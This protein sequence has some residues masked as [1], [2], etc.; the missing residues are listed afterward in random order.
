VY[1][2]LHPDRIRE[3]AER[4][5]GEVEGR[6]PGSG[7]GRVAAEVAEVARRA[8]ERCAAIRKGSPGLRLGI[9]VLVGVGLGALLLVFTNV[10]VTED[11][12]RIENF[13]QEINNVLG[14]V[15][16]LGAAIAFLVSLENRW[17]RGRALSAVGELRAL[18]HV[19]D[20]HQLTKDSY[21]AHDPSRKA[22]S[23]GAAA[24]SPA[25]LSR[26]FEFCSE[27]LS[28][29]AKVGAVYV[30]ALPDPVAL[31]E[32]DEL[33]ELCLGLSHKIWQKIALVERP[34]RSRHAAEDDEP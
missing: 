4:L 22:S 21:I 3:T 25:D 29:T 11:M 30:H 26:Y 27:L 31:Q 7:L 23:T 19:I 9:A 33:E 5:A 12:W 14:T 34:G 17:R 10:R 6:F 28:I 20:M 18:A 8:G 13:V 32:V 1:R 15:V 2:T 16:F 24:M